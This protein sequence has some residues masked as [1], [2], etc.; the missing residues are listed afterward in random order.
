MQKWEYL[1]VA[2]SQEG[3]RPTNWLTLGKGGPDLA[4]GAERIDVLNAA[5]QLGWELLY[6]T[7]GDYTALGINMMFGSYTFKRPQ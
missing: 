6:L 5:G 3:Q 4:E 1:A 7:E 2:Y